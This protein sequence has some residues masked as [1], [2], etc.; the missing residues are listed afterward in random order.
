MAKA[1]RIYLT[2]FMGAGKTA[3]GRRLAET[4]GWEAVDLD[5]RIEA[6]AGL[7]I[8]EIFARRGEAEFREL[9]SA[10]LAA[11]LDRAG[12]VV[13]TGGGALAQPGALEL[14][15]GRGLIVWLKLPFAALAARVEAAGAEARPLY[16]DR[17]RARALYRERLPYYRQADLVLAVEGE[18]SIESVVGRLTAELGIRACVT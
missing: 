12:L 2:G 15:R 8:A 9:E 18:E 3:V 10:E 16:G 11:T 6:A 1:E 5:E 14:V 17:Q 13:A 4:L 7:P